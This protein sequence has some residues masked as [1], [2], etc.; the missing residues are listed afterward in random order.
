MKEDL[1]EIKLLLKKIMN[2][3]DVL[4]LKIIKN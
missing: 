4:N 2:L 1:E 3:L